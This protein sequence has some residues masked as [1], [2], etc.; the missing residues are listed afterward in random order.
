MVGFSSCSLLGGYR[1]QENHIVFQIF[2]PLPRYWISKMV[3][4]L[5]W[6]TIAGYLIF[7]GIYVLALWP[8]IFALMTF[9]GLYKVWRQEI[10]LDEQQLLSQLGKQQVRINWKDVIVAKLTKGLKKEQFLELSTHSETFYISL[11]F[12]E[13]ALLWQW[14][15]RYVSPEALETEAYKRLP[16]YQE[17]LKK[18]GSLINETYQ[19]LC[20]SYS[21]ESKFVAGLLWVMMVSLGLML[22]SVGMTE[23]ILCFGPLVLIASWYLFSSLTYRLEMTSKVITVIRLWRR[24]TIRWDEIEYIEHDFGWHR[25]VAYGRNKRLAVVGIRTLGE[26]D[27]QKIRDML[28][29]QV[30]YRNI[31]VHH[32]ERALFIWSNN[33]S[34]V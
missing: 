24:Q 22:E 34:S 30:E 1:F 15:Q 28:T 14:V 18:V 17:W 12:F 19:P 3:W 2:R 11:K 6:I 21:L 10:R 7:V 31:K 32:K 16:V 23:A 20:A 13:V 26:K 8:A 5:F 4:L 25:W 9:A 33:V 29:A 27:R